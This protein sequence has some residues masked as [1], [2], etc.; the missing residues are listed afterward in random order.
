VEVQNYTQLK[1][2][3]LQDKLV[4]DREDEWGKAINLSAVKGLTGRL[5]V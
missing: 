4:G 3:E 1:L 2:R 5:F